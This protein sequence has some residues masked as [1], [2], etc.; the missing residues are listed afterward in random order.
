MG[1]LERNAAI[2]GEINAKTASGEIEFR[3]CKTT[4]QN[5]RRT[6]NF[7]SIASFQSQVMEKRVYL[8]LK[9]YSGYSATDYSDQAVLDLSVVSG[10][11]DEIP[12][13]AH[14]VPEVFGLFANMDGTGNGVIVEDFSKRGRES[15]RSVSENVGLA[16][17]ILPEKL[18]DLIPRISAETL[19]GAI[20]LVG[21]E[22][23]RRIGDFNELL[24]ELD[25][26][27]RRENFPV[28]PIK[29]KIIEYTVFVSG[30]GIQ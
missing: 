5:N 4:V 3:R 16:L 23:R 11:A 18:R 1:Y 17:G 14:E 9:E 24:L 12:S 7:T 2:I 27:G 29:E 20:F 28:L 25:I 22:E 19:A 26:P 6:T 8:G 10:I 30:D 15:V 21:K 13:L